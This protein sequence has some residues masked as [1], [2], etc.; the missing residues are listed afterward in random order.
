MRPEDLDRLHPASTLSD[1]PGIEEALEASTRARVL[2]ELFRSRPD[3]PGVL[4]SEDDRIAGA[5]SR[6]FVF[7]AVGKHL[8]MDLYAPRPIKVL[9]ERAQEGGGTLALP[10]STPIAEAVRRGLERPRAAV[11][12]PVVVA[13]DAARPPRLVDFEHVLL[14]ESRIAARRSAQMRQILATVQE[15][16]LVLGRD[17]RIGPEHSDSVARIFGGAPVAG[18]RF[19]EVLANLLDTERC[20]LA[21]DYVDSLFDPRVIESL[22]A[23]INPLLRVQARIAGQVRPRVLEFRFARGIED[24]TIR[25]LL[26]RVEDVTRREELALELEVQ[27]ERGERRVRLALELVQADADG[28]AR[29][30]AQ[31]DRALAQVREELARGPVERAVLDRCFREIHRLKG[32][33][34]LL[35][36]PAFEGA[37]HQLEEGL[38]ALRARATDAAPGPALVERLTALVAL[39]AEA[40]DLVAQ[41][42]RLGRATAAAPRM[43]PVGGDLVAA[44]HRVARAAAADAGREVRLDV[45]LDPSEVPA[46]YRDLARAVLTQLVRNAVVHGIEAPAARR[47]AGKPP[48]GT[49][50]IAL[51]A[52]GGDWLELVVQDDG[53]GVDRERVLARAAE[54]G[55]LVPGD[56]R[57]DWTRVLFAPGF[58]TAERASV[59]AGRGVGLDLVRDR[60]ESRGGHVAVHTERGRFTA[61]QVVLPALA[62]ETA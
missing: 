34:G 42:G 35:R 49:V 40:S 1:V 43:A 55:L 6:R 57:G 36:L 26:V 52:L 62:P 18:R 51:R 25:H 41:F 5:L 22:V 58:S 48:H 33:A 3:L 16:L 4:V 13:G 54:L 47:T 28:L 30:L 29:L 27:R 15:G 21:R 46:A 23:K 17:H 38:V 50:A 12:E 8:A 7:D 19:E 39:S 61:F 10:G 2:L 44:V 37:L 20:A 31:L 45:R 60:V 32:E 59:H 9:L 11:Y 53:G 14:A 56:A 24:G